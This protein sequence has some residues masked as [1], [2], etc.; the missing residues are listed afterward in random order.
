MTAENASA[1]SRESSVKRRSESVGR[2]LRITH[3]YPRALVGDGGC[4]WA[5]RGWAVALAAAGADVA[6]AYDAEGELPDPLVRWEHVPHR[7]RQ[8]LRAPVALE[9][10]IEEADLLVL[11]SGWVYH[12]AQAAKAALR[13]G[14][15]YILTP[16]GAYDPNV[17]HRHAMSKQLWW[18]L[19]ERSLIDRALG[20]HVFFDGERDYLRNLGYT[21][22]FIVAPTGLSAPT[23]AESDRARG[24]YL[25]WMGRFDLEHKGI[26]LLLHA[27]SILP[28]EL[29]PPAILRGPDWRGGKARAIR[30]IRELGLASSVHVG[31]PA[32]D[33]QKWALMQGA[34]LFVFPSRWESFGIIAL[35]AAAMG[36]PILATD[37]TFLGRAL[38]AQGA[39]LLSKP[40][41]DSIASGIT[42]VWL[43]SAALLGRRAAQVARDDFSWPHAARSFLEQ[44]ESIL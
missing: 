36:L 21:G 15:P 34:R 4:T 40:D 26:D 44:V 38:A 3:Y 25:L 39:A 9:S 16:H 18:R 5:V 6:V 11:H 10:V 2:P 32:Y 19:I 1:S 37:T 24:S 30:M 20:I 35:E 8:R 13:T 23:Y 12:N 29:R 27:L 28:G 43:P 33:E 41:P 17:I 42:T 14:T 31:P 22:P 7:G